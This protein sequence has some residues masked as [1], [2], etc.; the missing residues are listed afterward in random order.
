MFADI[1]APPRQGLVNSGIFLGEDSLDVLLRTNTAPKG[2]GQPLELDPMLTLKLIDTRLFLGYSSFDL[3]FLGL[4]SFKG[5]CCCDKLL[6]VVILQILK[7]CSVFG[8][9]HLQISFFS[10]KKIHSAI[11]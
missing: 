1:V 3:L 6:F 10:M 9:Q 2:T 8:Y 7:L 11:E 4:T 5:L